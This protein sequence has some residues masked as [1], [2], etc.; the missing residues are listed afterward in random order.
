[1]R[2]TPRSEFF[3]PLE[4]LLDQLVDQTFGT[5]LLDGFKAAKFP[6]I[7]VYGDEHWVVEADVPGVAIENLNV[8]VEDNVLTIEGSFNIEP[9][10]RDQYFIREKTH[11]KFRRQVRL[12]KLLKN[13]HEP[14]SASLDNGVLTLKWNLLEDDPTPKPT[15]VDIKSNQIKSVSY[16]HLTLPT[17]PYV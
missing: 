12:P 4:N 17:T 8:T 15:K 10:D 7:D 6:R 13:P 14:D 1:M 11:S 2:K 16:T 9:V 3:G 5:D